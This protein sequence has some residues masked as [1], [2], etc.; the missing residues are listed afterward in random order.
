MRLFEPSGILEL[1]WKPSRP[2]GSESARE[3]EPAEARR[4]F[5]RLTA[6]SMHRASLRALLGRHRANVSALDDHEVTAILARHVERG[7]LRLRAE[8]REMRAWG[9]SGEEEEAYAKPALGPA[10]EVFHFVTDAEPPQIFS[11]DTLAHGQAALG[12]GEASPTDPASPTED[13][14]TPDGVEEAF[15]F[16]TDAA[17]VEPF[18]LGT[19]AATV[20][21]L[22]FESDARVSP[23]SGDAPPQPAE[24]R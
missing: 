3:L 13:P 16:G 15:T 7:E 21:P 4:L 24:E 14:A 2:G 8:P 20:E 19:D 10:V 23:A 22:R 6:T 1:Y 5:R 18:T 11:F 9:P 17:I 12:D